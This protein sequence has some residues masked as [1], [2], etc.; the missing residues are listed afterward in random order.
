MSTTYWFGTRLGRSG[1]WALT[2]ALCGFAGL[3][4]CVV[5]TAESDPTDDTAQSLESGDSDPGAGDADGDNSDDGGEDT[6]GADSVGD[7]GIDAVPGGDRIEP[8]P[9]PWRGKGP[10]VTR[11]KYQAEPDSHDHFNAI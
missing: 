7:D 2:I 10:P 6:V 9:E 3:Q 11:S 1:F 5:S 4:G 8:E